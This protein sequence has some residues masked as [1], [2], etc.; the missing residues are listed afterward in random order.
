MSERKLVNTDRVKKILRKD[1]FVIAE[2]VGDLAYSWGPRGITF[3]QTESTP[4][5]EKKESQIPMI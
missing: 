3:A 5:S 2:S 1:C 4:K